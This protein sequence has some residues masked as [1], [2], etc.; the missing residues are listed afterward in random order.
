[1]AGRSNTLAHLMAL[2]TAIVW[3]ATFVST[4]I[5]LDH[6]LTPGGIMLYRFLIAYALIL[7][8][9]PRGERARNP[10]DELLFVALGVTGGSFY[11]ITENAALGHTLASHV[12]ILVCTA[13]LFTA[14][15]ARAFLR[16]RLKPLHWWGSIIAMTGVIVVVFNGRIVLQL[17]LVGDILSL[18]AALSWGC[19]TVIAR[20]LDNRYSTLFITRKVFFYGLLTLLPF[21]CFVPER[22]GLPVLLSAPVLWNL[23][24]LGVLASFACYI[25]WNRAIKQLGATRAS[26]YIYLNPVVTLVT[27]AI[28]LS[29]RVT[30]LAIAGA[31][32][33]L[34]GVYLGERQPGRERS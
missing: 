25:L 6:G 1:M 29:E 33:I 2:A 19:Y 21:F 4:K 27:S 9:A 3:G 7:P 8:F 15:L 31:L 16:E 13:P 20:R 17:D 34:A 18:A 23:L 11:F 12:A 32:L 28:V 5:L 10:R 24:F 22:A 14:L 30:P 26:N